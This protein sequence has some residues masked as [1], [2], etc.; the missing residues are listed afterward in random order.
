MLLLGLRV[1]FG[2]PNEWVWQYRSDV[3]FDP[4]WVLAALA[5]IGAMATL[6]WKLGRPSS[7]SD[8]PLLSQQ[9]IVWGFLLLAVLLRLVFAVLLPQGYRPVPAFWAMVIVSPIATSFYGEAQKVKEHGVATY[10]RNYHEQLPQK[11]FH[12]ATHPPGLPLLFAL[13]RSIAMH[14]SLQSVVPL[15]EQDLQVLRQAY[16]Y[17][18]PFEPTDQW[19]P[20]DA[21]MKAAW[22]I[23][24]FCWLFGALAVML[25]GWLLTSENGQGMLIA[26][27]ATTP[28]LLW[29][30]TTV[31]SVHFLVITATF[32]AAWKWRQE[33][34]IP[35]ALLTGCIAGVALWLAFKNAVPLLAV[36]LWLLWEQWRSQERL[37]LL[38]I[39]FAA[40]L[41]VAPYL[42][43]WL[44]FGFQPI[45]TFQAASAA[46]H[47]QAGTHARSYL[48][49]VVGNFADFAMA[50]GGGWLGLVVTGLVWW[51]RSG[52]PP[53]VSIATLLVLLLLDVSGLVRGEA[54]RL[55]LPFVPLLTWDVRRIAPSEGR[56]GALIVLVQ[57]LTA[58][59]LLTWLEFL[60]PF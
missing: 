59:A 16:R 46:H 36:A 38:Q 13:L 47:A 7:A 19:Y 53:S 6:C 32:A 58:L 30:Q 60:R 17:L 39:A 51:W 25:W 34:S 9:R 27:A 28:G 50:L 8:K 21:D 18:K 31:D 44:L 11:P 10:L 48:P 43:S 45:A 37:P 42:L 41:A 49:W 15:G 12:A 20:S 54:A 14:P 29:W 23:A 26:L 56:E 22:W 40:V 2:V 4:I 35:W 33:R 55:W 52:R 3:E 5:L 1:P 57:G 24:V